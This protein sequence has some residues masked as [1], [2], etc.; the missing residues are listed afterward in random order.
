MNV[1]NEI[2]A[3]LDDFVQTISDGQYLPQRK[4][5]WEMLYGM[6]TSGSVVLADIARQLEPDK[7]LIQIEKR[8]EPQSAVGAASG[9]RPPRQLLGVGLKP[10]QSPHDPR[11]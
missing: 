2:I 9:R 1:N 11:H 8:R 5:V 4:F 3:K 6:I 7:E 10:D